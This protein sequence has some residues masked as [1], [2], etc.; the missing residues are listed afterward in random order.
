[1][2]EQHESIQRRNNKVKNFSLHQW[3]KVQQELQESIVHWKLLQGLASTFTSFILQNI[4]A[5]QVTVLI[6]ETGS[7]KSTGLMQYLCDGGLS[8][9]GKFHRLYTA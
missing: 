1:M 8:S 7:G 4:R 2:R 3:D 6:G 9:N 5:N